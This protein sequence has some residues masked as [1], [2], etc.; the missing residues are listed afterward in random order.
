MFRMAKE[1]FSDVPFGDPQVGRVSPSGVEY[2]SVFLNEDGTINGTM[3]AMVDGVIGILEWI[4]ANVDDEDKFHHAGIEARVKQ[5][6]DEWKKKASDQTE[7]GSDAVTKYLEGLAKLDFAEFR[8]MIAVQIC[9]LAKVVVNG[10]RNLNNLVYPIGKLGAAKQLSHLKNVGERPEMINT[11]KREMDVD[12]Y[13]TNASE[14]LLCE[15]SEDRVRNIFDY[16]FYGQMLFIVSKEGKNLLKW[17]GS[18][19]WEEF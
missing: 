3:G 6:I 8:I 16:V 15:T 5:C 9:C 13:G 1:K 4:N 19:E 18:S 10:H 12:E 7:E 11:I 17:F 2:E 14:G